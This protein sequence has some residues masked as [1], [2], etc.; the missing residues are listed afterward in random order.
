MKSNITSIL[1]QVIYSSFQFV[2]PYLLG[3]KEVG[4]PKLPPELERQ[5]FETCALD[6]PE[7]CTNLVLVSKRVYT[8]SVGVLIVLFRSAYR[9]AGLIPS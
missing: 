1:T 5:I 8:W 6:Y 3:Q 9:V 7:I 2:F 4:Q